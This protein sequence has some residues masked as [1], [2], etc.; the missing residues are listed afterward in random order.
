MSD[1]PIADGAS[2]ALTFG[3]VDEP[4][5]N[6]NYVGLINGAVDS[7]TREFVVVLDDKATVQLDD[8]LVTRRTL[9][10]GTEVA[11]Y[12][13]VTE[14]TSRI[15]GMTEPSDTEYHA[16]SASAQPGHTSRCA[17]IS[18]LRVDPE[19]F[20]APD[21]G[22]AV[23]HAR[24]KDR[25]KAL[26]ADQMDGKLPIGFDQADEPIYA[27]WSFMNGVQGGHVSISGISGVAAKT[28]YALFLLYMIY[29]T[30]VGRA[31]LGAGA[32]GARALVFNVKGEDLLHLDRPHKTFTAEQAAKWHALG[33]ANP[34]P[35]KSVAFFAPPAAGTGMSDQLVSASQSRPDATVFGWT[36]EEFI[37]GGLLRFCLT[38]NDQQATQVGFVEQSVRSELA[39]H[40]YPLQGTPGAVVIGAQPHTPSRAFERAAEHMNS[41]DWRANAKTATGGTVVRSFYDL[42]DVL[43]EKL[44]TTGE[45]EGRHAP[46]TVTAFM[47]RLAAV[48]PRLGH[49]VRLGVTPV[50]LERSI[51]VVDIHDLH[52]SAQR[53]VVGS[54]SSEV[55]ESKQGKGRDPRRDILLDEL[56]KFAPREGFG[57]LRELFVDVAERGRAL[58]VFLIGAQ[59]AAS[60]V[61]QP[62]V[63]QPALKIVGRLDATEAAEY[64]FLTA[65]MRERA[66]RFM[67]GTMVVSQPRVPVPIPMRFPFPPYATNTADKDQ[68]GDEKARTEDAF[69]SL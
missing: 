51:N 20:V 8:L 4:H 67:P 34:G 1:S 39:R 48:A 23:E 58:G 19:K 64:K 27:D 3:P 6:P 22:S 12:G 32:S 43:D 26:Y 40:A 55:F 15:E 37:K 63:S 57:P 52:E 31:L 24:D 10:D 16:G 9:A 69:A 50:T 66:T 29:E 56:N 5:E 30:E 7:N 44:E 38:D 33:V 59:Q 46:G 45:W 47:R 14:L 2:T 21:P 35:F 36:P 65:E 42:I 68:A 28:S 13:I 17:I 61:A 41:K 49:L 60:R 54:L 53:M 25:T 62:V 18:V 11:H